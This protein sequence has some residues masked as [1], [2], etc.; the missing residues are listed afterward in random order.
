MSSEWCTGIQVP[1]FASDFEFE[2]VNISSKHSKSKLLTIILLFINRSSRCKLKV[3][4]IIHTKKK[5]QLQI[6]SFRN[7]SKAIKVKRVWVTMSP[8]CN[9]STSKFK[10][11]CKN[12][13][14]ECRC[15]RTLTKE[16]LSKISNITFAILPFYQKKYSNWMIIPTILE[17]TNLGESIKCSSR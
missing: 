4:I 7:I 16:K 15:I 11:T 8:I 5:P 1:T 2:W 12:T 17:S 13:D 10:L 9:Y 14:R 6:K 3:Y